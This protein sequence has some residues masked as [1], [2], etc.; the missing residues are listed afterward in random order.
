MSAEALL[1]LV[2]LAFATTW[3]PGPN[4]VMLASSGATFGMRRTAPHILGI[5]FGLPVMIIGVGFFLGQIFESSATVREVIRWL[6]VAIMLW[7]AWKILSAGGMS[8]AKGGARPMRFH[9]AA[10]FQWVNPKAWAM[11]IAVTSQFVTGDNA[12]TTIPIIALVFSAVGLTSATGWAGFGTAMTRW[13]KTPGRLAWFNRTMA[14]LIAL[15]VLF[16]FLE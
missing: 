7:I 10:A 1:S 2:M 4:N 8:S 16:L 11:V 12:Y 9:E 5:V 3:T 14:L 15:S 13:L 6:G